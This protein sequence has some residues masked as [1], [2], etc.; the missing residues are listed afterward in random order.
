MHFL[1]KHVQGDVAAQGYPS[2]F[3]IFQEERHLFTVRVLLH[4]TQSKAFHAVLA[5]LQ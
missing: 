3:P 1:A 5:L 4:N 2:K